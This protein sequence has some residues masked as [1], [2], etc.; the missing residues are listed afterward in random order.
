MMWQ[1][2]NYRTLCLKTSKFRRSHSKELWNAYKQY[3]CAPARGIF[4]YMNNHYFD[5]LAAVLEQREKTLSEIAHDMYIKTAS[6]FAV[7]SIFCFLKRNRLSL[8][9]VCLIFF[10]FGLDFSRIMKLTFNLE[11][12]LLISLTKF[13][14]NPLRSYSS[15]RNKCFCLEFFNNSVKIYKHLRCFLHLPCRAS[16]DKLR[17]TH[18]TFRSCLLA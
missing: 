13:P 6:Y 1:L 10:C 3:G 15:L 16:E 8:K 5:F 12:I 2:K 11:L 17:T 9:K 14:L 4:D 18:T 7:T